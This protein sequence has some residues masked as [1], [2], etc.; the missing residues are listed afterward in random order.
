MDISKTYE[1]GLKKP[2]LLMKGLSIKT[3]NNGNTGATGSSSKANPPPVNNT[4]ATT[5]G[6]GNGNDNDTSI[7]DVNSFHQSTSMLFGKQNSLSKMVGNM[8]SN[9][10][11]KTTQV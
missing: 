5:N 6:V 3:S 7:N 9:N 2:P 1:E 8:L 11:N 4:A 10:T